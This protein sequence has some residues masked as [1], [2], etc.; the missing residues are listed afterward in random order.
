[1]RNDAVSTLLLMQPSDLGKVHSFEII[2]PY[3][4][5]MFSQKVFKFG[6]NIAP[7]GQHVAAWIYDLIG[8]HWE[9]QIL[10][11]ICCKYLADSTYMPIQYL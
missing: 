1:M 8:M 2:S 10:T 3:Y 11:Y 5:K 9:Q 4:P 7:S 6:L